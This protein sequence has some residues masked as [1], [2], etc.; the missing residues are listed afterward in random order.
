M[1]LY[2][3]VH[4]CTGSGHS[5]SVCHQNKQYQA[6][7]WAAHMNLLPAYLLLLVKDNFGFKTFGLERLELCDILFQSCHKLLRLGPREL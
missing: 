4:C 6:Q 3:T 7:L 1:A 5:Q 2:H